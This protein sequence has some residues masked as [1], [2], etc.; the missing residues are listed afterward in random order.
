MRCNSK[1]AAAAIV[2]TFRRRNTLIT[3]LVKSPSPCCST[4]PRTF[5]GNHQDGALRGGLDHL[6]SETSPERASAASC[7]HVPERCGIALISKAAHASFPDL[8]R[9]A[10]CGRLCHL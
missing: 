5:L 2:H 7:V 4:V 9:Q 1:R 6:W 8:E 3:S 10:E